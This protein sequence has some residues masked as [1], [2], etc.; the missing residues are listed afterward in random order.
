MQPGVVVTAWMSNVRCRWRCG[1]HARGCTGTGRRRRRRRTGGDRDQGRPCPCAVVDVVVGARRGARQPAPRTHGARRP[2]RDARRASRRSLRRWPAGRRCARGWPCTMR[3][4]RALPFGW[5]VVRVSVA[6]SGV[7][8]TTSSCFGRHGE[9]FLVDLVGA[10][11]DGRL[12]R[13][14]LAHLRAGRRCGTGGRRSCGGRRW[15]RCRSRTAAAC[16]A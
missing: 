11:A 5:Q 8:A 1:R 12:Q 3:R 14:L 15:P 13:D 6:S 2:L 16:P 9:R 7:L 4:W 10:G